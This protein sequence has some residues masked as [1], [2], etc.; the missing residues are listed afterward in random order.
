MKA[1][2]FLNIFKRFQ[3]TTDKSVSSRYW[4][5]TIK[6]INRHI[7]KPSIT[8]KNQKSSCRGYRASWIKIL[9]MNRKVDKEW[10]AWKN[11]PEFPNNLRLSL[12]RLFQKS[13]CFVRFWDITLAL[14][15][16][17]MFPHPFTLT[18]SCSKI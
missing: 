18:V 15:N 2:S 7:S 8:Q 16:R 6:R 13:K 12:Q 11:I 5:I 17:V 10:F 1:A 9:C 3:E 4:K 14:C